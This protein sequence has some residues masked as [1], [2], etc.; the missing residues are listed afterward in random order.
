MGEGK[1]ELCLCP[2]YGLIDVIAKK[3]SLLIIGVLGNKGAMSFNEL[4]R[5]LSGISPKTLSK[6]LKELVDH[7]LV[8]RKVI[9]TKPPRVLYSLSTRGW[10]LRSLLIPLL[11]WV[12][13]QGG[14]KAPWCP[15]KVGHPGEGK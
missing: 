11:K 14:R 9:D 6:T 2:L 13:E 7:G 1:E 3:W 10:E 15:I 5:E 4:Q 12:S 8:T